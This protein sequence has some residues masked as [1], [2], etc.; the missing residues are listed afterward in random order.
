MVALGM[1]DSDGDDTTSTGGDRMT[2]LQFKAFVKMILT[3]AET[4]REVKVFRRNFGSLSV[5][6]Y[7]VYAPFATM[8][9]NIADAT[10]DMEKVKQVLQHILKMT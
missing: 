8:M 4:T 9:A 2:D 10:G 1:F 7:G 3:L 5:G 6:V